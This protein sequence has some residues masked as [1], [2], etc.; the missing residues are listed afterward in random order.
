MFYSAF[1]NPGGQ[2]GRTRPT[3]APANR[4]GMGV[5]PQAA[6]Q[7]RD[8][9]M[10]ML[11]RM[12]MQLQ[13]TD[14]QRY[15]AIAKAYGL[16]PYDQHGTNPEARNEFPGQAGTSQPGTGEVAGYGNRF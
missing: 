1:N 4:G 15:H 16:P 3:P 11:A 14:P 8:P 13:I 6:P 7:P 10:Q 5:P 2:M 12:I 9:V